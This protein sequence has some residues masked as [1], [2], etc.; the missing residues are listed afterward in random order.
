MEFREGELFVYT[1]GD[2]WELGQVKSRARDDAYY[3]WYS[4]G[5]TAACTPVANMHKLANAGWSHVE[6]AG[7]DDCC[8]MEDDW[9]YLENG[10]PGA[11]EDTWA[12]MCSKC[13]WSFRYDRGIKPSFCP[14]CRR[15]VRNG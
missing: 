7:E 8:E 13:G 11:P 9:E 5:D 10:I 3:C 6:R 2:R 12:Y 1:N 4:T 14:N 15:V